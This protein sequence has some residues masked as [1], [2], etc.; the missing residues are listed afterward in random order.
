MYLKQVELTGFCV[1]TCCIAEVH[2]TESTTCKQKLSRC[3][4]YYT[5]Q[6]GNVFLSALHH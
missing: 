5:A 2:I 4:K 6:K 1:R 3:P